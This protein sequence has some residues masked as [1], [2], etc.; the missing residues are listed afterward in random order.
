MRVALVRVFLFL[1][2]VVVG[3]F[4]RVRPSAFPPRAEPS[5]PAIRSV[6]SR[7]FSPVYLYY[8]C[9]VCAI[10]CVSACALR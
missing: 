8:S 5:R 2:P 3:P 4:L 1:S 6:P 7:A 10:E 9:A